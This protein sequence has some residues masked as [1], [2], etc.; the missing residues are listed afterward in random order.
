MLE[1]L[2]NPLL[3]PLLSFG[4]FWGILSLALIITLALTLAYK[5]LTDQEEMKRV[6]KD[7]KKM[8]AELKE[9]QRKNPEKAL[10]LQKKMME[11]NAKYM[12][13]SFK[14]TLYTMIP[15]LIV[16][17]WMSSHLAYYPLLPG[18]PF[19]VYVQAVPG[20]N[21]SVKAVPELEVEKL[22]E[23]GGVSVWQLRGGEGEYKLLVKAGNQSVEKQILITKAPEYEPP[24]SRFEGAIK[25]VRLDMKKVK[26]LGE[27]SLLG[28]RPGGLGTYILL[29]L[30]LSIA[31]R[32]ALKVH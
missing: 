21:V 26:P 20:V 24:V 16:F 1:S 22:N 32:K 12:K 28:W 30:A 13:H 5:Y 19:N 2:L 10:K 29:S 7:L 11:L 9:L 6:K 23:S 17:G 3:Y 18:Q 27:T 8:Q 4:Y 31:I 15:V 14:P 25:E